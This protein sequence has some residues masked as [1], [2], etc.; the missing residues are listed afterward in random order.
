[1]NAEPFFVRDGDGDR[2][3]PGAVSRG[4]WSATSLH[5][6]VVIG[7][8]GHEIERLHGG[9]DFTPARLTT[10]LYR[11]PDLS[12][13]EVIVRPVREGRRIKVIDAEFVSGGVSVARATCQLLRR[14]ANPPGAVWSPPGWDA[15]APDAIAPPPTGPGDLGG[16][17]ETRPIVGRFGSL[18]ARRLWM[19]ETRDLIG[20]ETLTPFVRAALAVDFASPYANAGEKGLAWINSDATLYLHRPLVGEWIGFEVVNHQATDGIAI[21]EC[22]LHDEVGAIGSASVAALVQR[23]AMNI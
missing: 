11:L 16:V 10:D 23:T 18:G 5:A 3:Q 9:P 8:L 22:W 21:A 20:G 19:R 4:P 15:P 6:R 7:L 12:P 13:A 17:W 2:F 14:T 1:M